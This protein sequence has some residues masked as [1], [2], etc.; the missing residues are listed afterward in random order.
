VSKR[1]TPFT[2]RYWQEVGGTLI[3]EF[4]AVRR[5]KHRGPRLLDGV[6][7]PDGAFEIRNYKDVEIADRDIIVVQTKDMRLGMYL[8]GQAFFS[9]KL[10]EAFGPA[11]IRTVAVC[12]RYDEIMETLA[13]A[14]GI[15]VIVYDDI[16]AQ[17]LRNEQELNGLYRK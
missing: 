10:M 15:E 7:V 5:G 9:A 3:E 8:M 17:D 1:E 11:S 13:R 14:H 2:R 16:S 12:T 4:P 6:I